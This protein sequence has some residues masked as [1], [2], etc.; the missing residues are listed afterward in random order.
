LFYVIRDMKNLSYFFLMV[1]LFVACNRESAPCKFTR[2]S[3]ACEKSLETWESMN[4][5]RPDGSYNYPDCTFSDISCQIPT[6]LLEKMTTQAVI[7]A[8]WEHPAHFGQ[9]V[10]SSDNYQQAFEAYVANTNAYMEL[11]SRKDAGEALYQRLLLVDPLTPVLYE[12]Q[13][14]EFWISQH[15]FLSQLNDEQK[16]NIVDIVLKNDGRRVTLDYY[17]AYNAVRPA[18]WAIVGRTMT[19]IGYSPFVEAMNGNEELKRFVEQTGLNNNGINYSRNDIVPITI[20]YYSKKYLDMDNLCDDAQASE[21]CA[22]MQETW[23]YMNMPRPEDSYKLV[24]P[25]RQVNH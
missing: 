15:V 18:A 10:F 2:A 21:L 20:A 11:V 23:K 24:I 4:M 7:Q 12:S 16:R 3:V 9:F 13:F 14:L 22:S 6:C 19:S 17:D 1:L 25:T 8:L 5:P